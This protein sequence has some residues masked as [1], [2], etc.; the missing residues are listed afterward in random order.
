MRGGVVDTRAIG[1]GVATIGV[2]E[3]EVRNVHTSVKEGGAKGPE[4]SREGGR[5]GE[6]VVDGKIDCV[7]GGI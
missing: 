5:G 4:E 3:I 1:D 2:F 7:F 6:E